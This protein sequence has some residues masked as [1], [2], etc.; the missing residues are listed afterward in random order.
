MPPSS[1]PAIGNSL[2]ICTTVLTPGPNYQ[3]WIDYHLRRADLILIFMDDP[4]ERPLFEPFA[5]HP[6][7]ILLPG[8]ERSDLTPS[9]LMDRINT[10]TQFVVNF[11]ANHGIDWVMALDQD[12]ILFDGGDTSWR[13]MPDVGHITFVNHEAVP[14][15]HE[16]S[17]FYTECTLFR[18]N[19][20][21]EFM[22][23]GNG[24]SAVR[25]TS[26]VHAGAHDF[27]GYRG[28]HRIVEKPAI[29][30][31]PNP[32]FDSWVTKFSNFTNFSDNWRDNP[33][34]P[35]RLSFMLRSRDLVHAAI[36]SGD[37]DEARAYFHSWIP[38]TDT[39]EKLL[40]TGA[41]QHFDPMAEQ[42]G[43]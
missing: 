23:Y 5:K 11:A 4:G 3:T 17:N 10:N 40:T 27:S 24:K 38:D 12:E 34:D 28:E 35:I 6:K 20:R 13:S 25:A 16:V 1:G 41:L 14:V 32:T 39:R 31:Y 43:R 19:G 33:D 18:I 29:L 26:G 30:H 9:G 21:S 7:V 15:D 42:P 36:E 37:W 8:H 22:A 2:V